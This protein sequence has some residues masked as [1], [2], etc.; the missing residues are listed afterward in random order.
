[1]RSRSIQRCSL[2]L[3]GLLVLL[4]AISARPVLA[5][6]GQDYYAAGLQPTTKELLGNVEKYHLQKAEDSLRSGR[7]AYSWDD[8]DFILRAFPN[9]PRGLRLIS[10]ICIR[11]RDQRCAAERYFDKAVALN[12]SSAETYLIYGVYLQ[13]AGHPRDAI[14]RYQ[15]AIELDPGS[16]NAHYNLGLTY[17]QLKDFER[18]NQHA[19]T[20]YRLGFPLE[21]LRRNLKQAGAWKPLPDT[22]PGPSTDSP[23]TQ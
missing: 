23:K 2:L 6:H 22:A 20:A 11:W 5:Q 10:E 8:T 19:Q 1:M 16:A 12:P 13:K 21:G 7:Y 18:A 15:Q 17:F 9:H 14:K 3:A 4:V